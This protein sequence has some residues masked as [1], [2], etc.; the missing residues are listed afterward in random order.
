VKIRFYSYF[1][2]PCIGGGEV[3]LQHQ[4][5]ELA[6]RGHE[7]HVH[8]TPFTNLNLSEQVAA[9]DTVEGGVAVHRRRS[10]ALP[11]HNPFEQDAVTPAFLRDVR[12]DADLLV[13]MGYP[14]LH[15]D[16]LTARARLTG[17]PLVVQNYVTA[18]FLGE[19]L[20]G[21]GGRNKRVRA[22]YWKAWTRRALGR[23]RMVIAD[24]P[25]AGAALTEQLGLGN[26][27]VHI[28][29]AVDPAEFDAETP[30]A[31]AAVRARLGL[32]ADRN[33]LA[34]SRLSH[35]KGAD[36]LV[37]A[38][39]PLLTGAAGAG[40]RL[41]IPGAVNEPDFAAEVRALAAPLG[42][43]VVFGP[44]ARAEL[45]ALFREADVVCLPSRGETVGGVVFEGMYSGALAVVSD[46]VEAA[47]DDYVCHERNGL[48][49][50]TEDVDALR[51]AVARGMTEDL[52]RVR[53]AGRRMVEM[54][55]TWTRSV[56]RLWALYE[57]ALRA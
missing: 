56:D 16:L 42:D 32:G 13:C 38:M 12:S 26:V 45:V 43:R 37:R 18:A 10:F 22:A 31:R 17:T 28:G 44:V 41:V 23:A 5:E 3:I 34:P 29:M 39:A 21:E 7:V 20:A 55:F 14:S 50:P 47:R 30:A 27:R 6:R 19:I 35:Q 53:A 54:R 36:L 1:Y 51:A 40:W 15:L 24:S 25:A 57:E 48:L 46:A 33:V 2:P 9:G 52:E 4:A 8:T 49:V 11:F